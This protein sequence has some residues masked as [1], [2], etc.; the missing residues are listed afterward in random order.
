MPSPKYQIFMAKVL[1]EIQ[2]QLRV[3]AL[4]AS[5]TVA[6]MAKNIK[7]EFSSEIRMITHLQQPLSKLPPQ[8]P[9]AAFRYKAD[10]FARVILEVSSSQKR[11]ALPE[12]ADNY[13]LNCDGNIGTVVG[14]DIDYNDTNE[15]RLSIWRPKFVDEDNHG[16]LESEEIL[17]EVFT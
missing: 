16:Y 3:I 6:E 5:G 12:I 14:L 17:S 7:P 13:I 2:I 15:G 8:R 4:S 9:D 11:K 10:E 1:T